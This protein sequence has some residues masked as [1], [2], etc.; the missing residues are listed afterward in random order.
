MKRRKHYYILK[1]WSKRSDYYTE[2]RRGT[3]SG[4]RKLKDTFDLKG[5]HWRTLLSVR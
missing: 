3:Y 5:D 2:L 1:V 4:A